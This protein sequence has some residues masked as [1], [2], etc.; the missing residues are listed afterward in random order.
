MGGQV[1]PRLSNSAFR[2]A[3]EVADG[4]GAGEAADHPVSLP[5]KVHGEGQAQG[6]GR[7]LGQQGLAELGHG[8]EHILPGGGVF[9]A[10]HGEPVLC[11]DLG[12]SAGKGNQADLNL[13][14]VHQGHRHRLVLGQSA[15]GLE[16]GGQHGDGRLSPVE[17]NAHLGEKHLRQGGPVEG[18]RGHAVGPKKVIEL[19]LGVGVHKRKPP[20]AWGGGILPA[21]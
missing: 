3:G 1:T 15:E 7:R 2:A 21:G 6:E 13:P 4:H 8:I 10:G 19:L 12:L 17:G 18:V 16:K 20:Q 5:V 9:P 11:G 14:V